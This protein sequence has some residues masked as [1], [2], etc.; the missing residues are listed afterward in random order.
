VKKI[1]DLLRAGTP[2]LLEYKPGGGTDIWRGWIYLQT[3]TE[4]KSRQGAARGQREV[5]HDRALRRGAVQRSSSK[6][7]NLINMTANRDS[8]RARTIGAQKNFRKRC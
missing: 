6:L 7:G 2:V 3:G 5:H 1:R 8:F 4:K